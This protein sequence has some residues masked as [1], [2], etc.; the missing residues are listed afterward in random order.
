MMEQQTRYTVTVEEYV[1]YQKNGYLIVKGLL[2]KPDVQKLVDWTDDIYHGRINL[3]HLSHVG[4]WST[5]NEK[6][7]RLASARIHNPH[8]ENAVAEWGLLHPKV[9]DALEGLIGMDIFA[10]QSMLF[11]NPP[12]KGGQGWHQDSYYIQTMPDTLI[13]AWYALDRADEQNG[14]LWVAPGSHV[15]PIYPPPEQKNV[16]VHSDERH[17]EG[18]FKANAASHMDDEVNNLSGVANK[19]G[20]IPVVLDPGDVLFFHSHLLHRSYKNE[21]PDRFRRSY[22]CHYSNARS[23]VPWGR[24]AAYRENAAHSGHLLVRGRTHQPYAEPRLGTPVTLSP[25]Q[26]NAEDNGSMM[27]AMPNGDMGKLDM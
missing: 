10:L 16:Y 19:Y 15:E 3:D 18:L 14:C 17:I 4:K 6:M 7:D 12:G 8:K 23:W 13:G 1:H 24:G 22:V 11:F 27:I 2:S 9:L 21:T 20:A 5:E 25:I 26:E